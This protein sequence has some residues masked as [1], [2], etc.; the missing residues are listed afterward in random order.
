[1]S[2]RNQIIDHAKGI[3]IILMVIGHCYSRENRILELIYG[4]HMPFFFA[5]SGILYSEKWRDH[6]SF[7]FWRSC[8]R[9]LIPY[10][11]FDTLFGLFITVLAQPED[12]AGSFFHSLFFTILP[13]R[14]VTAT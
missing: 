10:L 14:G 12:I 9:L 1:M 13:L 11:I 3:A 5:V 8:S 6:V 2:Q 7:N 4:F